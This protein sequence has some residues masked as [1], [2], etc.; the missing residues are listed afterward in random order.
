MRNML[1]DLRFE[2]IRDGRLEIRDR[3]SLQLV[4]LIREARGVANASD[5]GYDVLILAR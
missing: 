2:T 5:A 3:K 4:N 1:A